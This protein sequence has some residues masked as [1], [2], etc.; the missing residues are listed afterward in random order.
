MKKPRQNK[1][2]KKEGVGLFP[3]GGPGGGDAK[4]P[5][6]LCRGGPGIS[7]QPMSHRGERY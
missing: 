3:E 1:P 2:K 5:I 6:E 7:V 4:F